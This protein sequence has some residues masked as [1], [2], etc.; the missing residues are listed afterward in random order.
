VKRIILLAAFAAVCACKKK[1]PEQI[2]QP[3]AET[4]AVSTAAPAGMLAAPGQYLKTTVGHVGE[5]K[6]AAAL[7]EKTAKDSLGAASEVGG[8]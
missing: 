3:K 2:P 8:K 1:A 6:A 4:P 7:F 5:A